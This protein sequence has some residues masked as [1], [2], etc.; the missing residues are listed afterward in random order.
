[1]SGG[2]RAQIKHDWYQTDQD[3]VVNVLAKGLPAD[4]VSVTITATALSVS[5]RLPSGSEYSLELDLLHP[6]LPER[7]SWRVLASKLEVK[8]HKEEAHRWS[9]LEGDGRAPSVRPAAGQ[10]PPAYTSSAPGGRDWDAIAADIR[11]QEEQ[12]K[13]E[14]EEALN[15]LFQKIYADGSDDV[16]KAMQ[17]SFTESGGTVLSTN[18]QDIGKKK[19]EIKSP[20]GMEFKKWD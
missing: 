4:A 18:W 5:A 6:V 11:R 17:K 12:E 20:D 3:V 9:T 10:L 2:D 19:T 8:L 1:M 16:K 14:G 13:P 15:S 7:S